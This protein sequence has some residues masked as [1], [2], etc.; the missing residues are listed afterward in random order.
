[1]KKTIA[2]ILIVAIGCSLTGCFQQM[3][4][5]ENFLLAIKK[6]DLAAVRAEMVPDGTTGSAYSRLENA[7]LSEESM[8]VLR[9]LY[10]LVQYTMGETVGAEGG[11]KLVSLEMKVPDMERI[12]SLVMTQILVSGDSA[13]VVIGEMIADGSVSQYMKE[14]SFA[15]KMTETDG[16]FKIPYGDKEN[17]EFVKAI[18]IVE[19]I[20]FLN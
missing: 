13:S 11:T 12:R 3:T 18:A 7:D 17:A 6:M 1:M 2:F 9:E 8:Q 20:D 15:V 10:S 19:M 4:P 16:A 14:Y 5:V